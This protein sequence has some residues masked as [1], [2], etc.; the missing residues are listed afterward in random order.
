MESWGIL[1]SNLMQKLRHIVHSIVNHQ[2]TIVGPI[3]FRHTLHINL[4]PIATDR[5]RVFIVEVTIC[6]RCCR[7]AAQMQRNQRDLQNFLRIRTTMDGQF[8]SSRRSIVIGQIHLCIVSVVDGANNY[9]IRPTQNEH[10]IHTTTRRH[11]S[12]ASTN[13]QTNDCTRLQCGI[14]CA[15]NVLRSR[16]YPLESAES[17]RRLIYEARRYAHINMSGGI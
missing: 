9:S 11:T 1:R 6:W 12:G 4:H 10:K 2:P 13:R 5:R 3:M 8:W 15:P 14:Q 7:C 16:V 17:G